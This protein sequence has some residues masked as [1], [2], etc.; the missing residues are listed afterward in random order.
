M[1]ILYLINIGSFQ[2]DNNCGLTHPS[3]FVVLVMF[4][5]FIINTVT[6]HMI[7][8]VEFGINKHL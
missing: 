4:F 8:L 6:N 2:H 7:F 5:V 3:K 1:Q